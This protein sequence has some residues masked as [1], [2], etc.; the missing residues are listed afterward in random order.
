MQKFS[1]DLRN[2]KTVTYHELDFRWGSENYK[3]LLERLKTSSRYEKVVFGD[4]FKE[5]PYFQI[6]HMRNEYAEHDRIINQLYKGTFQMRHQQSQELYEYLEAIYKVPIKKHVSGE[7]FIKTQKYGVV[8]FP[9]DMIEE[10]EESV[11]QHLVV[12]I[13]ADGEFKTYLVLTTHTDASKLCEPLVKARCDFFKY[14]EVVK[15]KYPEFAHEQLDLLET[16]F[17]DIIDNKEK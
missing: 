14:Y 12:A 10:V 8:V 13:T 17:L 15:E 11:A 2:L 9:T 6:Q 16:S 5:A 1:F 4:Q 7:R 3:L